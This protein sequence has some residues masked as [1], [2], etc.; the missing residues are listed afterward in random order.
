MVPDGLVC[1]CG[2]MVILVRVRVDIACMCVRHLAMLIALDLGY[3]IMMM[4]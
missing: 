3:S 2:C 4:S 1:A